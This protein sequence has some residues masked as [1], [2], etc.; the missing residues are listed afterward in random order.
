MPILNDGAFLVHKIDDIPVGIFAKRSNAN[1]IKKTNHSCRLNGTCS[2]KTLDSQGKEMAVAV[3]ELSHGPSSYHRFYGRSLI[4]KVDFNPPNGYR[5]P[6][7][8]Y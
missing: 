2:S 6:R 4:A 3:L 8:D 7:H 5:L 1:V